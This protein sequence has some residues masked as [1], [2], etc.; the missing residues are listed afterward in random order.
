M[1]RKEKMKKKKSALRLFLVM[2]SA[3]LL[4]PVGM[5]ACSSDEEDSLSVQ[6]HLED[7][8]G[9][10]K[11]EFKQGE[12]II[13]KLTI[14]NSTDASYSI[15]N[16]FSFF[17]ENFFRV[18]SFDGQ[19]MGSSWDIRYYLD[20]MEYIFAYDSR[21]FSC[22]WMTNENL[23]PTYPLVMKEEKMQPLPVGNYYTKFDLKFN[24]NNVIH[25]KQN[26]KIK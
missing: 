5:A 22:P 6:F 23:P 25:C 13:F 8:N 20:L 16:W 14:Y 4:L 1:E 24:E 26:F 10:P 18:Y 2:I 12:N 21:T 17:D 9:V 19:D 3:C 15:K 11:T 7:E